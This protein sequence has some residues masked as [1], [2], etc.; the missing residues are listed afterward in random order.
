MNGE[1]WTQAFNATKQR[2]NGRSFAEWFTEICAQ[3]PKGDFLKAIT[4]WVVRHFKSRRKGGVPVGQLDKFCF[5][6][7]Q[8]VNLVHHLFW[9]LAGV[10]IRRGL[11]ETDLKASNETFLKLETAFRKA[12]KN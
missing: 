1:N 10:L 12:Q 6:D 2:Y 5:K 11:K 4:T 7:E 9:Y 8:K 3:E